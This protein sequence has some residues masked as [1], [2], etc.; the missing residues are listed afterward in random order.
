MN[1]IL[2][3]KIALLPDQPGVYKMF[4]ASGEVIY[5]GKAKNL[6][7]RVRQYF[8]SSR[9]HTPKVLAMVSHIENFETIVVGSETEALSLE[10]NLIKAFQPKYNILLKDD[11]HFPYFRIDMKRDFPRVE[12]VRSVKQDGATYLGPYIVGPSVREELRLAYD[13]YPI[14]HCKKNIENAIAKRER[15]CLM[16]HIGKCCAPCSGRISREEYHGYLKEV[17]R[18]LDG[19]S[20]DLIPKLEQI[21]AE[22]A[23]NM[24]FEKAA[25]IRDKVKALRALQEKQVAITVKGLSADV[26]A[27]DS[28]GDALMI[29]ALYVRNGKV[30]GTHAFPRSSEVETEL[31]ELRRA[32]LMQ[33][34]DTGEADIPKAV[35]LDGPSADAEAISDLLSEKCHRKVSIDVPQRGEKRKLAEMAKRNCSDLLAK[36]AE[37]QK[38]AWERDEGALRDLASALGLKTAPSRIECFDNSHLFGTNTVSSM[39]VFKDG[40]PDKSAYRHYRIQTVRDGDD[41]ETMREALTRRFSKQDSRPDLLLLDGGKTQLAVGVEVLSKT[42]NSDVPIAAL[43][44]SE[45]W[46]YRPGVDE[47][48]I[49]PRNS[50]ALHLVQRIRDEAHRF[51][52]TYHRNLRSKSALY[53]QLDQIPGIGEKRKRALFDAFFTVDAIKAATEEQLQS[54]KGMN[55]PSSRAVFQYFHFED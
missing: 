24:E 12:I 15:P 18:L 14:R 54:V 37:L 27:A 40:K 33:Y 50:A 28:L 47:P 16:Y 2:E 6:K 41:I 29:F 25:L 7:N 23:E 36:N 19:K 10:S 35:L 20:G 9:N 13:L 8:Q 43:A 4:D 34:Y 17:I 39:V 32:F 26:F 55:A 46:M 44:E 42:N 22:Y 45:E 49:L 30:I 48:I 51:A 31:P 53:S 52:I 21:M 1:R 38:R 3:D 11:K 5:V